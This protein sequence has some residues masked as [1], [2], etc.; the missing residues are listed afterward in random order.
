MMHIRLQ[1]LEV[2]TTATKELFSFEPAAVFL[3][4][5]IG[6]GKSSVAR[7]IDYCF[8]GDLERTVAIQLHFVSVRL[9]LQIREFSVEIERGAE[10]RGSVRVTWSADGAGPAG[11]VNAPLD[12][13]DRPIH[14]D[15]VYNLSDLIFWF[16]GVEPIKVRKSKRDPDSALVRLSFRDVLWYCYLSQ[17][18]LDSSF[19]RLEDPNKK[20]KS[21]DAMRYFTGL[22][23]ERLS[24]LD[25]ELV[26][27]QQKQRTDRE[28]VA[29]LRKFLSQFEIESEIE[30]AAQIEATRTELANARSQ[31][32]EAMAGRV[33]GHVI[34]ALRTELRALSEGLATQRETVEDTRARIVAQEALKAEL[35]TAKLKASR[36]SVASTMLKGVVYKQ[37]PCCSTVL[38]E[39]R[40]TD[41]SHCGLC[42]TPAESQP[43][44]ALEYE[45]LHRDLNQ[46][47]DEL[48]ESIERHRAALRRNER[49]YAEM[50]AQKAAKDREL[51][52]ETKSYDS[53]QLAAVRERD[54]R[55][56]ALE[57]R[58]VHLQRL[59][60]MPKAI[61]DLERSAGALQGQ[62]DLL[63]TELRAE[64]ARMSVADK[65]IEAIADEFLEILLRVQYPG[66]SATDSVS[67]DTRTWMPE[68]AHGPDAEIRWSFL[69][70]GS[71]GKKTLFNVCYALA[72]HRVALA[73]DLPMPPF[74]IVDSP[75]KNLGKDIN[76]EIVARTIQEIYSTVASSAGKFQVLL[77]D[78]DYIPP[79]P[80]L[81]L[82]VADRLM[83]PGDLKNPPLISF[84]VGP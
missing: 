15:S 27:L 81:G 22:H 72:L 34:D 69:D 8:G 56:A 39:A 36:S 30:Q 6:A 38:N 44:N 71:G 19:F 70:A 76:K 82:I 1:H 37:C 29:Q 64:R 28:T 47:M 25:E 3:H 60:A 61:D 33:T 13:Q 50:Q 4:G 26:A 49:R 24:L 23:S 10:D 67:L 73:R 75:T 32:E 68:I 83:I 42:G 43:A 77:I 59:A 58:I 16:S 46:R 12:A 66:V 31:R 2:V 41:P 79:D 54:R 21:F 51:T 9:R 17:D 7:L 55:V 40:F 57:E 11:A 5:P 65:N 84:Y 20:Y 45:A 63:R 14:G 18:R 48:G 74:L 80:A 52:D 62:I 53:A 35:L 78:S